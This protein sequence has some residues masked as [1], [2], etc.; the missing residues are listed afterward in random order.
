MTSYSMKQTTFFRAAV[1]Y[2]VAVA[3]F[4]VLSVGYFTP[5]LFQGKELLQGDIRQGLGI[6]KELTD[7]QN[8]N[9]GEITRWTN[10]LFG[11][12]PTYQIAPSYPSS[13][14]FSSI[15]K[16]ISLGLPYPASLL[17]VMMLGFFLLM[18]SMNVR[19]GLAVLGAL[20]YTF[21]SY[22]FI[23]IEAG[24]IWKFITLS[25][26]PPFIAGVVWVYKGRYLL[27]GAVSTL[28]LSLQL[29][30]NHLQMTYYF[31]FVIA[32]II[33]TFF[34]EA[35][36]KSKMIQFIK[37]SAVLLL[38]GLIGLSVNISNLYHTYQYS[39][40][41]M[42]GPEILTP[43]EGQKTTG[44][45]LDH[46]YI[47]RW[48]YGLGET[49]SLLVPNVKGGATGPLGED[50]SAMEKIKPEYRQT[51]QGLNHYWGNQP[52]TSGPVYVGAFVLFLAVLAMFIVPGKLKWGLF[53]VT[54]LSILLSWGK[55]FMWFSDIFIN[56]F[57]MYNKFRTVSSILVIAEFTIP[58]L[59]ILALKEWIENPGLWKEKRKGFWI[60]FILTGGIA[61]LFAIMPGAFFE[62]MSKEEQAGLLPQAAGN[63]QIQ[64]I[65]NNLEE[66]RKS[67]LSS[68]AWRSLLIICVGVGA[69]ILYAF[70][71]VSASALII[72][73][74]VLTVIDM[75]GVDKRY[76]NSSAFHVRGIVDNPFPKSPADE[77]I[78]MDKNPNFRVY[79]QTVDSF[80][81][82]STSYYHKSIGGYH[83]AKLRR[84]QDLIDYQLSK[85]NKQVFDMLNTKYFIQ[86]S[87]DT[88]Q[89]IA[90]ENPDAY[91]N[92]WFV[93]EIKWVNTP[94]EEMAAL[95]VIDPRSVVIIN[96]EFA[97]NLSI[98]TLQQDTLAN[99]SLMEYKPNKLVYQSNS[100]Y[101]GVG[102]FS[103]IYYPYGWKATIDG[104][105][106]PIIRA[107]YLLRVIKIPAG[108]HEI[109]FSFDPDSIK[110]TE[111]IA[112][113]GMTLMFLWIIGAGFSLLR[114]RG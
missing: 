89:P 31:L 38:A 95:D 73:I 70:R 32:A 46:D 113:A 100:S 62:F 75:G 101:E 97:E 106:V 40:E 27:G 110:V 48:S 30:N 112:Y 80:N 41:S 79:N 81:D 37:A 49:F 59:A 72:G 88:R 15:E 12:M 94:D 60:S 3:F 45:G 20:F 74:I 9:D 36:Q 8:A 104:K 10:S 92:A 56:W 114:K 103:E 77:V 57:P 47:V 39:Q 90:I 28:M 7:Y 6:G 51:L 19:T 71:K 68:D 18:K 82:P 93:N 35:W 78:L 13:S 76:L 2:I 67:I 21:S 55:N 14:V 22:F 17:F 4:A 64:D 99:I 25:Y 109:I 50:K 53:F 84:Y 107:D 54:I 111:G 108:T 26:I 98:S 24:H 11:G 29:M 66:A 91:G 1:P 87:P 23:I 52:F 34:I 86:L 33:I 85:G 105:E 69:M 102:V 83:A 65:L 63:A 43:P 42:R 58:V 16:I 61:F 96:D 5:D 44:S